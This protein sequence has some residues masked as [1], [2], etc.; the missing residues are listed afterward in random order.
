MKTEEQRLEEQKEM[1]SWKIY[2]DEGWIKTLTEYTESQ[3]PVRAW[4]WAWAVYG[5][6]RAMKEKTSANDVIPFLMLHKKNYFAFLKENNLMMTVYDKNLLASFDEES[7]DREKLKQWE[8][9]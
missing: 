5:E 4:M 3:Y 1:I 2:L 9:L 7:E 8:S 6:K